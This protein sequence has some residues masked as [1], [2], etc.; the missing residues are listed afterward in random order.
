[1]DNPIL[2]VFKSLPANELNL[3]KYI[4]ARAALDVNVSISIPLSK[5][6]EY[7]VPDNP[8]ISDEDLYKEARKFSRDIMGFIISQ[9]N[10]DPYYEFIETTIIP[11]IAYHLTNESLIIILNSD[12]MFW[13]IILGDY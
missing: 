3:I 1:M 10:E 2:T 4:F 11:I 5:V 12:E 6:R 8:N 13:D 7:L 9:V